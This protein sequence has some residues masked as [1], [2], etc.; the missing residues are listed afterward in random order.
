VNFLET[1]NI[2]RAP[3]G[4]KMEI[5]GTRVVPVHIETLLYW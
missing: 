5:K 1:V 2:K 4:G 3:I